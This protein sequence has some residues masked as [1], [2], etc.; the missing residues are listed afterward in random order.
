M[1][2]NKPF[3]RNT[4]QRQI[5]LDELKKLST[6][7]TASELHGIVRGRLPKISLGTVYRNLELLVGMGVIQKL[8]SGSG[9]ARFDGCVDRHYHVRCACCGR[10]ADARAV[11][12]NPLKDEITT[13]EGYEV[14]G[15]RLEFIGICPECR[16]GALAS[17]QDVEACGSA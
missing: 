1:T 11:S 4:R 14:L 6:H 15:Y 7:P 17:S 12:S 9:E 2:D 13:L 5:L 10:L 8:E 3:R 16:R